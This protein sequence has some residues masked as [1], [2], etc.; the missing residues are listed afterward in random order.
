LASLLR[1]VILEL[2]GDD[3][4][5]CYLHGAIAVKASP[6]DIVKPVFL[7]SLAMCLSVLL[8]IT[9]EAADETTGLP[10]GYG[11]LLSNVREMGFSGDI[12]L[13]VFAALP[14]WHLEKAFLD[15]GG[16]IGRG[17]FT[18]RVGRDALRAEYTRGEHGWPI[19]LKVRFNPVLRCISRGNLFETFGREF[20]PTMANI[21]PYPDLLSLS[22]EARRNYEI[23]GVGPS[24]S[25]KTASRSSFV[26]FYFDF[27]EC[28]RRSILQIN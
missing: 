15:S 13:Q 5:R 28:A 24:Y 27:S 2:M 23:F 11:R 9:S 21:D 26:T 16:D 22:T 1:I 10:E 25:F 6:K 20:M 12:S 19:Q 8:P 14:G 3:P 18:I 7:L 17:D 4:V